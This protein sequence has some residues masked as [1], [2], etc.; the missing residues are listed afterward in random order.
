MRATFS[1][2]AVALVS[3]YW[4]FKWLLSQQVFFLFPSPTAKPPQDSEHDATEL[5]GGSL[6]IKLKLKEGSMF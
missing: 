4:S 5:S 3:F 6:S 2:S 1:V